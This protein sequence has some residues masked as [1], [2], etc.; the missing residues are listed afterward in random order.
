MAVTRRIRSRL[1]LAIVLT[2]LIPVLVAIWWAQTTVRTAAARF[3][4]P[5]IG[6]HLDRSLGLYQELARAVKAQMRQEAATIAERESLR[7]AVRAADRTRIEL[8]LRQG[9]REHPSLVT[10]A[11]RDAEGREL[12]RV[13]RDRPLDPAR[14]NRLEVVRPL[15]AG[16]EDDEPSLLAVFAASRARFDELSEM[17]QFLDTYRKIEHRREADEKGYVLAFVALLGLTIVAAVGVGSLLARSVVGRIAA[18][19]EATK[20]VAAGDLSIRVPEAGEDEL[21]DLAHGFNRML[22]E[23][24]ESRAR[25]E[26]LQRIGAWQEMARRLAHEIKNPLTPIQLAVQDVHRRYE[27]ADPTFRRLLDTTLEI[28]ED[29]VGTLRR[30]VSE[31]SDFARLP[32][33]NL[34]AEDL[35]A[36]LNELSEQLSLIEDERGDGELPEGLRSAWRGAH[37]G[38]SFS[39]PKEPAYV[40]MD[41]HMLRRVMLNLIQNSAQAMQEQGE[42]TPKILVS[43]RAERDSY[44]LDVEDSGP[45]I[46]EALRER[47]FDPYVTTKSEGTGLGLAIVK[48]VIVEHGGSI[49]AMSSELGGA[50]LRIRLPA[51]AAPAPAP[52]KGAPESAEAHQESSGAV[53]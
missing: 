24:A 15:G 39:L 31:F 3:Y 19:A 28:V 40:L 12:S 4:L 27:G 23:V 33:A 52:A 14:E 45:G 30:L 47:M 48:K 41:R 1:A 35:G 11:A 32:Q 36:F 22:G 16:P 10:L 49:T 38:L 6:V 8:E 34:E 26:Y 9:F 18:L 13:E 25:I 17:S 37:I 7:A 43:L 44:L 42:R 5:D 50:R 29:E 21:S 46:P 53:S 20:L 51:T 2:A